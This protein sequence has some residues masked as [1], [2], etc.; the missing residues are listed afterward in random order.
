MYVD[1]VRL[2][3]NLDKLTVQIQN[4]GIHNILVVF[5]C[6]HEATSFRVS[7]FNVYESF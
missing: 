6:L 4:Y 7:V 2:I 5:C 3:S 1:N